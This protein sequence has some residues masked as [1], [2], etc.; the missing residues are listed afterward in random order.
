L[1]PVPEQPQTYRL[2]ELATEGVLSFSDGYRTRRDEL[3]PTG[4][5]ILRAGDLTDD[6]ALAPSFKDH[7]QDDFRTK[8]GAKLS[9][10][11]DVVVTT[12]GTVGRVAQVPDGTPE[13]AYSPQLCFLRSLDADRLDPGWLFCWVRSPQFRAQ[14]GVYKDQTDMAP[15]VSLGDLARFEI[16]LPDITVQRRIGDTLGLLDALVAADRLLVKQLDQAFL[17]LWQEAAAES[18]E[19]T[20]VGEQAEIRKGVSYKGDFLAAAGTPLINLGSF[21]VDGR[22]QEDGTKYYTGPIKEAQM[23]TRGD[24]VV[25]NTDLTQ[26]RDILARP[27]LVPYEVASSTHHTFQLRVPGGD[28]ARGWLYCALRSEAVR[29]RLIGYATGT[30]VA[31]LPKDALETQ[32]IPWPSEHALATWWMK[33]APLLQAQAAVAAEASEVAAAR[34]ELLPPLVAGR[35]TAAE[36]EAA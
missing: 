29:R 28:A 5:P 9:R 36:V 25:A 10:T 27:V 21:G 8:I 22:L 4:I 32:E 14:L 23:L 16:T 34:D 18:V 17:T 3:G 2:K 19:V 30:T 33:T 1:T 12:K 31:A 35:L 20:T 6:G 13:H 24:L 26:K 7:V 11:G 15:Y